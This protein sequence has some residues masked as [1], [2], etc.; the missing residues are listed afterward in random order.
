MINKCIIK[1]FIICSVILSQT[2]FKCNALMNNGLVNRFARSSLTAT[3]G[4]SYV[5][6]RDTYPTFTDGLSPFQDKNN[7]SLYWVRVGETFKIFAESST[8]HGVYPSA[9]YIQLRDKSSN[10]TIYFNRTSTNRVTG[11]ATA[12]NN[13][14][15]N[16]FSLDDDSINWTAISTSGMYYNY[17]H[18]HITPKIDGKEYKLWVSAKIGN[19]MSDYKNT[20]ITIKTDGEGPTYESAEKHFDSEGNL[21]FDIKN[22]ADAGSGNKKI[23]IKINAADNPYLVKT[24]TKNIGSNGSNFYHTVFKHEL[25]QLYAHGVGYNIKVYLY[26]EVGNKREVVDVKPTKP[27]N[28]TNPTGN[29]GCI[30][31]KVIEPG[32][33]LKYILVKTNANIPKDTILRGKVYYS[34]NRDN[35]IDKRKYVDFKITNIFDFANIIELPERSSKIVIE[36][37]LQKSLKD[38]SIKP[39]IEDVI[40]YGK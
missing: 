32:S 21:H 38:K 20:G 7:R 25:D 9:N 13:E 17:T 5:F 3:V 40:V 4:N 29:D 31:S 15:K 2:Q 39:D 23:E 33:K 8:S 6:D 36:F 1:T 35:S 27:T 16:D 14:A 24:I 26:D 37:Y 10:S 30:Y 28:P 12:G 11:A 34:I 18:F 22:I 19:S